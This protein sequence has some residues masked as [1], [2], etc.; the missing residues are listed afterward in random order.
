[1]ALTQRLIDIKHPYY[2][3]RSR[4]WIKWRIVYEGGRSFINEFLKRFSDREDLKEFI[5]RKEMAY[6]PSFATQAINEIRNLLIQRLTEVKRVGGSRSYQRCVIGQD[7]GVDLEGHNILSFLAI[8][9][10][11]QL[12]V[13]GRVGIYVDMPPLNGVTMADFQGNHPYLYKFDTEDI[14]SWNFDNRNGFYYVTNA[15]LREFIYM[16]DEQTGLTSSIRERFRH[17]WMS[18]NPDKP[19]ENQ[20][21]VQFYND[22][23]EK[24]DTWGHP[25]TEPIL[26][27]IKQIPFIILELSNSLFV[28]IADYQIALLNLASSDMS[29]ILK[30][31]LPIYTEQFDSR[32]ENMFVKK[33]GLETGEAADSNTEAYRKASTTIETGVMGGRRYPA[34]MDRPGFINPSPECITLSMK[35]QEQMKEEIRNLLQLAIS[36]LDPRMASAESKGMDQRTVESGLA[37]I[38]V[39]LQFAETRVANIWADYEGNLKPNG[40]S[41]NVANINYPEK[42]D[43]RSEEDRRKDAE[44]LSKLRTSVP[45]KTFNLGVSKAIAETLLGNKVDNVTL[46]RIYKEI[47]NA[48][49][50]SSD[51][52]Q[53]IQ[54]VEAGLVDTETASLARGYPDGSAEKAKKDHAD[55]LARI[56]ASQSSGSNGNGNGNGSARGVADLSDRP[57]LD[58]DAEKKKAKSS[59]TLAKTIEPLTAKDKVRGEGV[60]NKVANG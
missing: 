5:K 10:I 18:P 50:L 37:A 15:L 57:K 56:A 13:M 60:S 45:S 14:V 21:F 6:N 59:D 31:N 43:L 34:G 55:R 17:I 53:I 52:E 11:P 24:I 39:E 29:F 46:E 32:A 40:N 9:I 7:G 54:D 33:V 49:V 36:N 22:A 8:N 20:V 51:P 3:S 35:K 4:E 25:T 42:Y 44:Q 23:S 12:L 38:G 58:A 27:G 26:L 16:Y 30:A 1:M 19:N 47:D 2:V 48:K 41:D 28:D